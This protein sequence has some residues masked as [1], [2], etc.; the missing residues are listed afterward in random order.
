MFGTIANRPFVEPKVYL[1]PAKTKTQHFE[2]SLERWFGIESISDEDQICVEMFHFTCDSFG[3]PVSVFKTTHVHKCT[4][5][6]IK[7][8]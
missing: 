4:T 3:Q 1:Q 8:E 7:F 5:H 2:V 6:R